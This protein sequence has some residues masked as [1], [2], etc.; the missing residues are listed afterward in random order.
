MGGLVIDLANDTKYPD[1]HEYF[2]F[3]TWSTAY[4]HVHFWLVQPLALVGNSILIFTSAKYGS[5]NMDRLSSILLENLAVAD[6]ILS[7]I[8]GWPVYITFVARH[9]VLGKAGCI[10]ALFLTNVGGTAEILILAVISVYRASMLKD[11]FL[12]RGISD[13]KI[14]VGLCLIWLISLTPALISIVTGSLV[15]YE[16]KKLSCTSSAY[17]SS[18]TFVVV[19]LGLGILIGIPMICILV[20]NSFMLVASIRYKQRMARMRSG[21]EEDDGNMRAVITVNIVCWLFLFSW[22]PYVVRIVCDASSV[23]LPIW[24]FIFQAHFLSLNIVFNPIIYTL[25]NKSFRH[26]VNQ[27]VFGVVCARCMKPEGRPEETSYT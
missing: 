22:S 19:L 12:F 6:I 5:L 18:S 16:P 1:V 9:W 15:Y 11:P 7:V 4:I 14:K 27:R 2:G 26:A 21:S 8:G 20:S 3:T 24:F 13:T 10:I 25:T 23:P 17:T